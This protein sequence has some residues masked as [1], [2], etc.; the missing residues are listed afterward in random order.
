VTPGLA[1]FSAVEMELA[2]SYSPF[3]VLLGSCPSLR[4]SESFPFRVPDVEEADCFHLNPG[5]ERMKMKG[6]PRTILKSHPGQG[7][8]AEGVRHSPLG[9]A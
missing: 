3:L 7:D 5:L 2:A 6:K 8:D 1:L 4:P 9:F